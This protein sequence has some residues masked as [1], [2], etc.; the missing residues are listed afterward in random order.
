MTRFKELDRIEAALEHGDL[1]EL[2][3]ALQYCK[4]RLEL[5]NML[6]SKRKHATK[7]WMG[8]EA[9]VNAALLELEARSK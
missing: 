7:H 8:I 5:A 6:G 4:M 2:R 1:R 9:R 3:W